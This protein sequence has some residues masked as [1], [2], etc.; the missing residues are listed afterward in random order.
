MKISK[1]HLHNFR[2]YDDEV[3]SFTDGLNT[4][5]GSTDAGKSAI[6]T[7][8][9]FVINNN[10]SG[11]II[12][13]HIKDDKGKILKGE[14]C[15]VEV[16]LSSGDVVRRERNRSENFYQINGGELI[17]NFGTGVPDDVE[18]LFNM[19]D[20]NIQG[21]FESH[22]LLSDN[23]STVAKTLN[24]MVDL[25]IIDKAIANINSTVRKVKKD[26]E[27]TDSNIK[28]YV[29]ELAKF[30]FID[31]MEEDVNA[32]L[33][34]NKKNDI[35]KEEGRKL[36]DKKDTISSLEDNLS[37]IVALT[38]NEKITED[39]LAKWDK[40]EKIAS[41]Y[42]DVLSHG[43]AI[44]A[45]EEALAKIANIVIHDKLCNILLPLMDKK[46]K[47]I[48]EYN[49]LLD[50]VEEIEEYTETLKAFKED[51]SIG[52]IIEQWL[53]LNENI[54]LLKT[55]RE[56][57]HTHLDDTLHHESMRDELTKQIAKD[58]GEIQGEACPVCGKP[59]E[60]EI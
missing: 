58:I 50:H 55:K 36:S 24:K 9:E 57:L 8:L 25:E 29:E 26:K 16:T 33:E 52:E 6:R 46:Q 32:L 56:E 1:L 22:F 21:Q 42:K 23:A 11:N 53:S 20:I 4:I 5:I 49:S 44:K 37:T 41:M 12:S 40:K 14:T 39:I 3:I 31:K 34:N 13:N 10:Q 28:K 38:K 51:A 30:D 35:L 45:H 15:F 59:M 27:A 2:A 47:Y 60:E 54:V 48:K 19:S 7:A 17:R 18:A 43:E